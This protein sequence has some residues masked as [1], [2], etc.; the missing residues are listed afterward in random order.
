MC[1][2][3]VVALALQEPLPV[4]GKNVLNTLN[5]EES[6][7]LEDEVDEIMRLGRYEE[8]R[9]RPLKLTL[10]SQMAAETALRR[11]Y[12]LKPNEELKHV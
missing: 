5:V 9:N 7:K 12:K 10:K 2:G 3:S 6:E 8:G 4:H 11:S 1:E